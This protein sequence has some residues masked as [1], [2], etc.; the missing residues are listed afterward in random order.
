MGGGPLSITSSDSQGD[1]FLL[2][3]ET[4][5]HMIRGSDPQGDSLFHVNTPNVSLSYKLWLPPGHF[6]LFVYMN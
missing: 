5:L 3:C 6:G 2:V 1:I 4:A